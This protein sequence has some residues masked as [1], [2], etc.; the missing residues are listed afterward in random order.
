MLTLVLIITGALS[1]TTAAAAPKRELDFAQMEKADT[2]SVKVMGFV[3]EGVQERYGDEP[4]YMI[5]CGEDVP[6]DHHRSVGHSYCGDLYQSWSTCDHVGGYCEEIDFAGKCT[7]HG[8]AGK[9]CKGVGFG[10]SCSFDRTHHCPLNLDGVPTTK[11]TLQFWEFD[12]GGFKNHYK[13]G[14]T[15]IDVCNPQS[16]N[17][18]AY[19]S[20]EGPKC[21]YVDDPTQPF[22]T[23]L[24]VLYGVD[25]PR[26]KATLQVTGCPSPP[27]SPPL[28]PLPGCVCENIPYGC[29]CNSTWPMS[30]YAQ[31]RC[32]CIDGSDVCYSSE[33]T[34]KS[35]EQIG[36]RFTYCDPDRQSP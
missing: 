10:G 9:T 33:E 32:L 5:A 36:G 6:P 18:N 14:Q 30:E 20:R 29:G 27:P 12:N 13:V 21:N 1:Y 17:P 31:C 35:K 7:E 2:F 19:P 4:F 16:C 11:F 3:M 34:C 15:V 24:G 28:A 23:T 22:F 8:H 26:Y 25:G